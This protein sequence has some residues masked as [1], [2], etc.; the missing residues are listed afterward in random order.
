[1]TKKCDWCFL[2][3][4]KINKMKNTIIALLLVS[5]ISFAQQLDRKS[6]FG[7]RMEP[8]TKENSEKLKL[9]ILEG[10]K[11]TQV[12]DKGT[13]QLLKLQVDD[14][15]LTINNQKYASAKDV[16]GYLSTQ[17]ENAPIEVK[18]SR[19]GKLQT[20]KGKTIGKPR[21]TNANFEIIYDQTPFRNGKLAVIINKPKKE[22]KHPAMLFIP[23]YTCSSQD[24]VPAN[25]SYARI[26]KAYSDAGFV[27][28]RVE[29]S[30]LGDSQNTPDC[31][32]TNLYDEIE[33]FQAGLDKL[34]TLPYVDLKNI[35]IFGHSMGGIIA[36]ALTAKND[37]RGVIVNGTV[38][39]SFF[40]YTLEMNRLQLMLAKP[41][42]FEYEKTC[43]LQ[44]EIA[45]E[46]YILKKPI[47]EIASSDDRKAALKKD[48]EW[49]GGN[50]I[51][52]RNQEYWRQIQ[53]IPLLENWK[54][55]NAKVLVQFGGADIQA[56]SKADHEQ[57]VYTVNQFHPGNAELMIFPEADHLFAKSGTL[58]NAYDLYAAGKYNELFDMYDTS[59]GEK[60]VEW[61]L[62]Q[63]VK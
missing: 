41:D 20:I 63:I 26:V 54:N 29:K 25:Y 12:V 62:K 33:N 11:I 53:E 9:K 36:P 30:G 8:I 43:R 48:W 4:V 32:S 13:C 2:I 10:L 57:I 38:A 18:I 55:T 16:T 14:V 27:V 24:N 23:G 31:S 49:D 19:N 44:T 37:V 45:Y 35:F 34:K 52:S 28:V 21:E 60:T 3:L 61:S 6:W 47:Q 7:A 5:T 56:F 15:V 42:V 59:I 58:Q 1:L 39:K 17:K 46:Y 51:F 40:E 22:G 50:R